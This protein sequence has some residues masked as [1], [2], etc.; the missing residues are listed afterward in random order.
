MTVGTV[1]CCIAATRRICARRRKRKREN[2]IGEKYIAGKHVGDGLAGQR[3]SAS[4][5]DC[6]QGAAFA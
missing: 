1:P 2:E 6:V 3:L 5:V 4:S